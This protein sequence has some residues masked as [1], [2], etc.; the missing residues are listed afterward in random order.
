MPEINGIQ[1]PFLPAGGDQTR[2][3]NKFPGVQP[4]KAFKDF[5]N[6][7]LEK[8][9]FSGHA[10]SRIESRNI[11]LDSDAINRLESAYELAK[12]KGAVE[13]LII[14]D[15]NA[16]I[17]NIPNKTVVTLFNKGSLQSN[18]ISNIDSA[19]FA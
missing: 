8:V 4:E 12:D 11:V 13:S 17:V 14:M 2:P 1:V 7:A 5:L 10:L 16:F 19:V 18:V 15:D 9:K 3:V 6:E